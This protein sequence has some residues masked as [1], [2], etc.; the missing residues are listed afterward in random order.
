M[1]DTGGSYSVCRPATQDADIARRVSWLRHEADPA[2]QGRRLALEQERER[3]LAMRQPLTTEQAYRLFGTFLGLIPPLAYMERAVRQSHGRE[4]VVYVI[5][6]VA[7]NAV[8]CFVGRWFAGLLG[9]ALSGGRA[10][11]GAGL[12]FLAVPMALAWSVVTGGAGG[13]PCFGI[14]ALFGAFMAMPV[15]LAG[16]PLFAILH[17]HLS[18]GGMIDERH[19][20]P[21]AF[22]I[23]LTIA[24]VIMSPLLK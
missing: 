13:V 17:R 11:S 10:R 24:A 2:A 22:G 12:F 5:F 18:R 20:W 16:F 6:C 19:A 1:Y 3:A 15:A 8:C 4:E 23:P 7:M 9:R 14:G 21:L